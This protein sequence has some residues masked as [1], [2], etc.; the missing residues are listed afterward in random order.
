MLDTVGIRCEAP[1]RDS[2]FLLLGSRLIPFGNG[3]KARIRDGELLRAE[4]SLARYNGG[5]LPETEGE[6]SAALDLVF[7]DIGTLAELEDWWFDRLD[8][9]RDVPECTAPLVRACRQSRFPGIRKAAVVADDDSSI[10]WGNG[11]TVAQV[12]LYDAAKKH[13][14]PSPSS[15]LE[16][17]LRPKAIAEHR[18][19]RE[20]SWSRFAEV[21]ASFA[22]LLPDAAVALPQGRLA[23]GQLIAWLA[24]DCGAHVAQRAFELAT[25]G[26]SRPT[27]RKIRR[28]FSEGVSAVCGKSPRQAFALPRVI[29]GKNLSTTAP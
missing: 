5:R 23:T 8:L 18:L 26:R 6:L 10:C 25:Q 3:W 15:R 1:L 7:A 24:K 20:K 17:R 16:I 11:R 19:G 21:F 29:I 2:R 13:R 14:T 4:G 27:T 28:Q 12:Q 22:T 9:A